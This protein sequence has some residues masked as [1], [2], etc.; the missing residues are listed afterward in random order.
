M[1]IQYDD[2]N[3]LWNYYHTYTAKVEMYTVFSMYWLKICKI[4]ALALKMLVNSV[5]IKLS[6]AYE[7]LHNMRQRKTRWI[8][9]SEVNMI[10]VK[11]LT[12]GCR[13]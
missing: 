13:N 1:H 6:S 11:V 2:M 5:N 3:D 10:K 7:L 12:V 9:Y 8:E 4:G